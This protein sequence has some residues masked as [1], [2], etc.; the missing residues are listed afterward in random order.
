[1]MLAFLR[2]KIP[3]ESQNP[4]NRVAQAVYHPL[5]AGGAAV[6]QAGHLRGGDP[7]GRHGDPLLPAG[8]RIHA[9]HQRRRPV[10]YAHHHAGHLH[11][12]GQKHPAAD[13]PH[14]PHLSGG[15]KCLRQ[16]RPG[17]N[18]HRPG[19]A[20]HDR[21]H[22]PPQGPQGLAA[23]ADHGRPHPA[24]GRRREISGA[25]QLLGLSH[26]DPHRHARPPASRPPSA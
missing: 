14:H 11:Y 2:G 8:L 10:V 17:R 25:L 12:R 18:R 7:G 26:Q 5:L 21:D 3:A 22:H 23:G 15:G 16:G 24:D 4:I 19:A 1:M 13:G 6:P 9:A 20:E